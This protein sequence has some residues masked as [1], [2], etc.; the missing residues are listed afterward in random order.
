MLHWP[1][2]WTPDP[3]RS[4]AAL[5]LEE[6]ADLAEDEAGEL[7]DGRLTEE[8]V[9]DPVHELAVTLLVLLFGNHLID[10]GGFVFT[11]DVKLAV[12][13]SRGRKADV[14]VYFPGGHRP[15]KRGLLRSPPDLL[16][17]V[18]TPTPRDERRDRVEKMSDYQVFGVRYY[19]LV[20]PAL[21]SLEIFELRAG[22]YA[23]VVG[24]TSGSVEVPGC[25]GL[26]MNLDAFWSRLAEL[27]PE[28]G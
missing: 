13:P 6:W 21:G 23:K 5:T 17:E 3:P 12:R 2:A 1:A 10:K 27:G 24:A 11:S 9:P 22:V 8:E 25:E 28:D 14:T 19:W 16:V 20:D 4:G 18:V 26:V 15:P 7:V